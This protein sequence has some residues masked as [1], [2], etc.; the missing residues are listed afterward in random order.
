M[1]LLL[2]PGDC[3]PNPAPSS[4]RSCSVLKQSFK[5]HLKTIYNTSKLS[6]T[7]NYS[8]SILIFRCYPQV[9]SDFLIILL[10][11]E[12]TKITDKET[13]FSQMEMYILLEYPPQKC[14]FC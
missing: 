11:W 4:L 9:N 3:L 10:L 1:S 5:V 2:S 8:S 6:R 13:C 14:T 12:D 7:E